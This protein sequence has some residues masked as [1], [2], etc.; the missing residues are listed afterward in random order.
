MSLLKQDTTRKKWINELFPEPKP[1]FDIGNNK[2]Y[3]VEVII[4]SAVYAKEAEGQWLD[5]YYL[6]SWNGYLEEKSTWELFSTIMHFQKMIST[7]RKDNLKKPM[8]ISLSLNSALPIAKPSVKPSTK[9]KQ[10][11][12]TSSTKQA[13]KWDIGWWGFSFPVL[14]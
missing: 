14:S 5:L 10:G 7:F 9:Q 13:K 4:D 6:V 11:C 1:K 8:V 2:K 3:K 12:P